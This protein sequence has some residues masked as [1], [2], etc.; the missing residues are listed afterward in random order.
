VEQKSRTKFL[1]QTSRLAVEHAMA[2]RIYRALLHHQSKTMN[3]MQ[4]LLVLVT[5]VLYGSAF[6][7]Q[8]I[9]G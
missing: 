4:L 5:L 9:F 1:P 8:N 6:C 7:I 2:T 3:E